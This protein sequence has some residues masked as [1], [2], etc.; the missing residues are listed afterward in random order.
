MISNKMKLVFL[1]V[2]AFV[3]SSFIGV[4]TYAIFS[5]SDQLTDNTIL[6]GDVEVLLDENSGPLS[7]NIMVDNAYPGWEGTQVLTVTNNGSLPLDYVLSFVNIN[8]PFE[9]EVS[10]D[11]SYYYPI[12]FGGSAYSAMNLQP[13]TSDQVTVYY[14]IFYLPSNQN[15]LENQTFTFDI[16]VNAEQAKSLTATLIGVNSI[17]DGTHDNYDDEDWFKLVVNQDTNVFIYTID[18]TKL[19]L[20]DEN[21]NLM[22]E[23]LNWPAANNSNYAISHDLPAGTYYIK[24]VNWYYGLNTYQLHVED[25]MSHINTA[26]HVEVGIP[27]SASLDTNFEQDWYEFTLTEEK[28]L[29]IYTISSLDTYGNLFIYDQNFNEVARD[30]DS[31]YGFNFNITQTLSAGTYY[32]RV[33]SYGGHSIGSYDLFIEE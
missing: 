1:L 5:D 31:A 23:N 13:G 20:Y 33:S 32:V 25:S 12:I 28:T 9:L 16:V 19:Y 3:L 6:T 11:G 7:Q 22:D 17:T 2:I 8:A 27:V 4:G 29:D 14:R 30:D 18:S 24:C 15:H 10:L 26:S 21:V